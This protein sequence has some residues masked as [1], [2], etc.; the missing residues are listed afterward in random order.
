MRRLALRFT[1]PLG[2]G[3]MWGNVGECGVCVCVAAVRVVRLG[4]GGVRHVSMCCE[5]GLF[6][7]MA[8][9]GICIL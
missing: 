8:V 6:V 2:M 9:Q 7:Y 3:G 5:S 4:Q 1:K